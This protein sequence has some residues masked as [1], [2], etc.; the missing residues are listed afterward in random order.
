MD[1]HF[2]CTA[3]GKC[4]QGWIPLTIE[5]ALQHAHRFPLAVIWTPIRP[6]GR[7]YAWAG[8]LGSILQIRRGK[9]VVLRV[10]PTAY[11][12]SAM[13]CPSLQHDGLCGI[14]EEKP[15]RCRAMPFSPFHDESN[16][17]ELLIPRA[18]W[19]CD[20]ST[21]APTVY[22]N[23]KILM[24]EDYDNELSTI[25]RETPILRAYTKWILSS[26]PS[27]EDRLHHIANRPAG[28]HIVLDFATLLARVPSAD[29]VAFAARQL[30]ILRAFESRTA[31]IAAFR[32]YYRYYREAIAMVSRFTT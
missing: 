8:T 6:G 27:V 20:T 5:D 30:P 28:G 26:L 22:R 1:K 13:P 7:S 11:I 16:Q 21:E 29:T 4:C 10:S 31:G 17:E 9:H 14:H 12:P 18:G 2:S 15:A 19:E 24:R 23:G 3:C 25:R 32:D